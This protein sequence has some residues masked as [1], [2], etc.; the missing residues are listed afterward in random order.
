[1]LLQTSWNKRCSGAYT[2]ERWILEKLDPLLN[3]RKTAFQE[4]LH[5]TKLKACD[6]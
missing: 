3:R 6:I 2:S 4:S 5:N 1:M